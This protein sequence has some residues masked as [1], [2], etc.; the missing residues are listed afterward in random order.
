MS[1]SWTLVVPAP[2]EWISSNDRHHHQ[3]RARLTRAW[4]MAGL[5]HGRNARIP[6]LNRASIT[7][8]VHKPRGGRYDPGNLYP[9]A[10]ALVDGFV[11]AGILPDDDWKH[12]DGPDMRHGGKGPAQLVITIREIPT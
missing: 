12:L 8:H 7:A 10:K 9:T 1:G 4:R 3:V 5:I 11:D 6:T 2:A